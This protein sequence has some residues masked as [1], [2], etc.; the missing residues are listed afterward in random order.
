MTT[1]LLDTERRQHSRRMSDRV[2]DGLYNSRDNLQCNNCLERL[3]VNVILLDNQLQLLYITP[4]AEQVNAHQHPLFNLSPRFSLVD[5]VQATRFKNFTE[6]DSST[7]HQLSLLLKGDT[8]ADALLLNCFHMPQLP[9]S[10][11]QTPAYLLTLHS[12]DHRDVSERW[13]KF[14]EQFKLTRAEARLC[15]SLIEGLSLQQY[16]DT[17]RVTIGTARSQL[18]RIFNKTSTRR[19]SDLLRLMYLITQQ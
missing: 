16:S 14:C 10:R 7:A 4:F 3:S 18:H 6:Q 17:W 9:D 5:P 12:P 15:R 8:P 1:L 19:Q 13:Q 2:I 11:E